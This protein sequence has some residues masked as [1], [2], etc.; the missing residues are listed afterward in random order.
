M[1]NY[2]CEMFG[3]FEYGEELGYQELLDRE[4]MLTRDTQQLLQSFKAAHIHY[5]PLGDELMV[6][7]VFK[8]YDP[9]LFSEVCDGL[10]PLLCQSVQGR[11]L[12]VDKH[13]NALHLCSLTELGWHEAPLHIPSVKDALHTVD[14]KPM[15]RT[16][17]AAGR[18][19]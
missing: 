10:H 2:S 14:P 6:Q 4:A 7:C 5:T 15:K 12:F 3:H 8:N 13:L 18:S 11:I 16:N 9:E 17:K 19:A 1:G